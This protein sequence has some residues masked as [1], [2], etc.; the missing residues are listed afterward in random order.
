MSLDEIQGA[1]LN[2]HDITLVFP[3]ILFLEIRIGKGSRATLWESKRKAIDI[4]RDSEAGN[5]VLTLLI[6]M[7][8]KFRNKS[9]SI[10]C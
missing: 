2:V 10:L 8:T 5:S 1:K 3:V 9:H 6:L 7:Y 4:L